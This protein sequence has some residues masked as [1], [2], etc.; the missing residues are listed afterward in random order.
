MRKKQKGWVYLIAN[1]TAGT[2]KIG[3]SNNPERRLQALQTGSPYPLKMLKCIP[4]DKRLE[5]QLHRQFWNHHILNEW[6]YDCKPIREWFAEQHHTPAWKIAVVKFVFAIL[7][8]L[9]A[10][11]MFQDVFHLR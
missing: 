3:Y 10:I 8:I 4:G 1:E 2:L 5:H 6:F 11:S 7:S 9:A